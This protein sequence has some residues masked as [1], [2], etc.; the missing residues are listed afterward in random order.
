MR[1]AATAL[2]ISLAI[3]GTT[4][5]GLTAK[6]HMNLVAMTEGSAVT[7]ESLKALGYIE[8]N[9]NLN[10]SGTYTESGFSSFTSGLINGEIYS[11]SY[12]GNLAGDFG[13]DIVISMSST[14]QLGSESFSTEGEVLWR[15]DA[16]ANDYLSF[17]YS[18]TGEINPFWVPFLI[19][20]GSGVVAGLIVE[21]ITSPP[22]PTTPPP[23]APQPSGQTIIINGSGN[24]VNKNSPTSSFQGDFGNG[25]FSGSVSPVPEPSTYAMLLAGLGVLGWVGSRR[26]AENAGEAA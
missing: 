25:Q 15:Y 23:P 12:S 6:E 4:A 16:A 2:A 18:E 26:R 11:Q 5:F 22:P 3:Q 13:E 7:L 19:G 14:G 9:P 8:G 10:F 21:W 20:V 24:T 1:L 17:E